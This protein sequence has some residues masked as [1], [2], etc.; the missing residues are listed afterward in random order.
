[1]LFDKRKLLTCIRCKI[2]RDECNSA[3]WHGKELLYPVQAISGMDMS[4]VVKGSIL[5]IDMDGMGGAAVDE[6]VR[7]EVIDPKLVLCKPGLSALVN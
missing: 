3:K 7:V 6:P 4:D 5:T 1:M 2:C